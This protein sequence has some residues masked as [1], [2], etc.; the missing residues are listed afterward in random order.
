MEGSIWTHVDLAVTATRVDVLLI[1]RRR[2]TKVT[3][4]QRTHHGVSSVRHDRVVVRVDEMLC[5]RDGRERQSTSAKEEARKTAVAGQQ[6]TKGMTELYLLG[7]GY[8]L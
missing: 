3:P 1:C 4:D 2:W 6:R 7:F 5:E 8:M